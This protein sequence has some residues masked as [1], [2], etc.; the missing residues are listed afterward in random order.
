MP[1][2]GINVLTGEACGLGMRLLC[3]LTEKG[4]LLI[5]EFF[6]GCLTLQ[7]GSNWNSNVGDEPAV[8]SVMLPHSIWLELAAFALLKEGYDV[9]AINVLRW[10]GE[11]AV[12]GLKISGTTLDQ[13]MEEHDMGRGPNFRTFQITGT[14]GTRNIHQM[15]GRIV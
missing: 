3:D 15:S 1:K 8:A 11:A 14:A 9:A 13:V 6:G 10:S 12:A 4:K 2:F 5:E 7:A